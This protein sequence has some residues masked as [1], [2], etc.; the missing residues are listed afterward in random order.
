MHAH[1]EASA[2]VDGSAVIVD[3]RAIGGTDFAQDGAGAGHDVGDAEAVADFDQLTARDDGFAAGRKFVEGEEDG[4]GVV[5]DRDAGRAH[6]AFQQ[7]C[8]VH[9]AFA[10]ASRSDV[11]FEVGVTGDNRERA[12]RGAAQV[13]V[14]NYSG[15]VDDTAQRRALEGGERT[16]DLR[17]DG[18]LGGIA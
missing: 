3:T 10:A 15:G 18:G 2:V 16:L 11:V 9:V 4:G 14:Q 17:C 8:G 1:Q 13:G 12:E 5:V 6:Q 7:A